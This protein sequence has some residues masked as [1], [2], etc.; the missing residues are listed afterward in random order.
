MSDE[1]NVTKDEVFKAIGHLDQA[2][3]VM[4]REMEHATENEEEI[5]S[6]FTLLGRILKS[7][8]VR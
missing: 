3:E 6:F 7:I 5:V 1:N 4:K 8:L 2:T